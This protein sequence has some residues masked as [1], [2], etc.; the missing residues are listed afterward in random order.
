MRILVKA[1]PGAK[2]ESVEKIDEAH[3]TVAVKEPP[4][5]GR[6]NEA[7]IKAL[8]GYFA[9]APERVRIVSGHTSRQ[10]VVEVETDFSDDAH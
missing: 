8:A 3:F 1:K 5:R 6:A 4:I 10:K 7:I 2:R 9:V